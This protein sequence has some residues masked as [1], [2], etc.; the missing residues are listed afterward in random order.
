MTEN[1]SVGP[2]LALKTARLRQQGVIRCSPDSEE[3]WKETTHCKFKTT[4]T[5]LL[6]MRERKSNSLLLLLSNPMIGIRSGPRDHSPSN[7]QGHYWGYKAGSPGKSQ[8]SEA[9]AQQWPRLNCTLCR[10]G[11]SCSHRE[12]KSLEVARFKS[13]QSRLV[14]S[15]APAKAQSTT[16]ARAKVPRMGRCP[17]D[18]NSM[19][20]RLIIM[21][22]SHNVGQNIRFGLEYHAP[23]KS[24]LFTRQKIISSQVKVDTIQKQFLKEL[25]DKICLQA[26]PNSIQ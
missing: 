19:V 25:A 13:R 7:H 22:I 9:N 21:G 20:G 11:R 26:P 1:A 10:W 3:V 4:V 5:F 6:E 17:T 14:L 8:Y 15:L 24:I 2:Y 16:R 18:C 12:P 23:P